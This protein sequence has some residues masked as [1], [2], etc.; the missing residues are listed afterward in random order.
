MELNKQHW[1][2]RAGLVLAMAGNAVGLGN[3]L[4]FPVQAV[5]NGGGA[6]LIPYFVCFFLMGIP[7]LW[8]EWATGRFGGK[9][10]SHAT[11][12]M[13]EKMS[14]GSKFWKYVGVLGIFSTTGVA[15]YY[16]FI[17]SWTLSYIFKTTFQ[18]FSGMDQMQVAAHFTKFI[19][20]KTKFLGIPFESFIFFTLCVI[21]NVWIISKGISK[22]IEKVAL[23]GMPLLIVFAGFL[24][25]KGLTL[26]SSGAY[27]GC[28]DCN[29][30]MAINYL[31]EPKYTSLLDPKVWLAA[32]GQVFFTLAVGMGSIQAYASFVRPNDDIALNALS[33]GWMNEFVE[34]VL[35]T[36]I[37][38]PIACGYLGFDWVMKNASFAMAFQTMPFL[39]TK[40][41]LVLGTIGGVFWFGLLF[42]AGITSSLAM[43]TPFVSFTMD[44]FKWTRIKSSLAIGALVYLIGLPCVF[45]YN[46]GVFNEYDYWAGTV[47]LFLFALLESILFGWVFGINRG[48]EEIT[49]G[50][51][52]KLLKIFK[53][54]I[55]YVTPT[56][57]L[58][59]F[60][61]AIFNPK[62]NDYKKAITEKWEFDANS[63]IGRL[64]NKSFV[65][66]RSWFSE[67]QESEVEGMISKI[68]PVGEDYYYIKISKINYDT[69]EMLELK[70][71]I[72]HYKVKLLV[73]ENDFVKPG[74][75]LVH[76]RFINDIFYIDLSR[77]LLLAL[78]LGLIFM[79]SRA[80]SSTNRLNSV[81]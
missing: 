25:F 55:K 77:I 30:F 53:P 37:V 31:F 71:Y 34:V 63:I 75:H 43:F 46:K 19:D 61:G 18:L 23:I 67:F 26:G 35:G 66:N 2:S 39:F 56:L 58:F 17:E 8:V 5:Q 59:I 22:G 12:F 60:L 72:F 68:G 64:Q 28:S 50:S 74:T 81:L 45:F 44:E 29:A 16:C 51:D 57:L 47:T 20:L 36:L 3:F 14:G 13:F 4:R 24:A 79:V 52:V 10:G 40:W 42:F 9:Y 6:F 49:H 48:W 21:L 76:G 38:I 78:L 70:K 69:G 32:A 54:I 33:A 80:S 11:P 62:D 7:L 41:G 27:A 65:L 73:S 15:T 1:S